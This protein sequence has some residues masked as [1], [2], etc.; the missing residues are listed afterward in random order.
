[1]QV[2][3]QKGD[4]QP[5]RKAPITNQNYKMPKMVKYALSTIVDPH[6]RGHYKR[7][8]MEAHVTALRHAAEIA[9]KKNK[10]NET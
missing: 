4:S 5:A 8:M 7:M 3:V 9:A 6:A 1:M 10:K 2:N